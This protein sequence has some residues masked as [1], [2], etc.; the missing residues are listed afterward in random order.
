M[1]DYNKAYFDWLESRLADPGIY[2]GIATSLYRAFSDQ[3][4]LLEVGCGRGYITHHLINQFGLDQAIFGSDI[5]AYAV[6]N[7]VTSALANKLIRCDITK[8]RLP[9]ENRHFNLVFSWQLLEH[10]PDEAAAYRAI[11][12]MSRVAGFLQ[13][14]SIRVLESGA[15]E[16]VTHTLI[17]SRDWW[18]LSFRNAGWF[19]DPG[20]QTRFENTGNW[21][22][23]KEIL[24]MR[25]Q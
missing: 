3:W 2:Y 20:A 1:A 4:P 15:G 16:D 5:S 9:F 18:V 17:R 8:D 12:E 23:T 19:I 21:A 25:R 22:D 6:G 24:V 13:V 7:P 14:H 10:M 11:D